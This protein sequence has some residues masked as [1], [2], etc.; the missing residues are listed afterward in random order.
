MRKEIFQTVPI[1]DGSIQNTYVVLHFSSDSCSLQIVKFRLIRK[2]IWVSR[3][4]QI[5][6]PPFHGCQT[7]SQNIGKSLS[8]LS[9]FNW[10]E[11][12]S[13]LT[14]KA[15]VNCFQVEQLGSNP[16]K[17]LFNVN[18]F[19]N[20]EVRLCICLVC[21]GGMLEVYFEAPTQNYCHIS[22][23]HV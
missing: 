14:R 2:L 22:S 15:T 19:A 11:I 18:D 8:R 20:S 7:I 4:P 1:F 6:T 3:H 9:N 13:K 16:F 12:C 10:P 23:Y 21:S 5:S 17:A